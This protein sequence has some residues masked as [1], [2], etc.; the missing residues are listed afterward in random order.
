MDERMTERNR[1]AV[2]TSA[3]EK[4]PDRPVLLA[5]DPATSAEED[6]SRYRLDDALAQAVNVAIALGQPLLVTGESGCGK[7]ALAYAIAW[8][9]G[10]GPVLRF[11]TRSTSIWRD[12]FYHH[13]SLRRYFIVHVEKREPSQ[14]D[15]LR[16]EALALAI[17]SEH[18]R[19]VL[20][21][22]IDKAPKDFPNDLLRAIQEPMTYDVPEVH[23]FEKRT[24]KH[25]HV[26]VI[27]SNGRTPLPEAFL[28][29][30]VYA[31]LKFPSP[32]ALK[33]IV[34]RRLDGSDSATIELVDDATEAFVAI[35]GALRRGTAPGSSRA[36][37]TSELLAWVRALVAM[38]APA[39]SLRRRE[40]E[41]DER[42]YLRRLLPL[43]LEAVL[44]QQHERT[45]VAG[46]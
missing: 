9:L 23:G 32:A 42:A 7:T 24:Q 38:R 29:R 35:R 45:I 39:G 17:M 16:E 44:K 20:I 31:H 37:G 30:C 11:D 18:T 46:E 41:A 26:V 27:T 1:F 25:R 12:V 33:E 4:A 28:R 6:G 43:G 15:Y 14:N 3:A 2:V 13:D 19:V 40:D 8:R 10:A 36:P 34:R 5:L 21:D 22:E